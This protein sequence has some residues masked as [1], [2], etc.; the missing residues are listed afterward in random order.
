MNLVNTAKRWI[1]TLDTPSNIERAKK[2]IKNFS[3]ESIP[4]GKLINILLL[5][6]L[7]FFFYHVISLKTWTDML[8]ITFARSSGPGGQNVNKGN[9]FIM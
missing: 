8:T 7:V 5:Y 9:Y 3:K 6:E 1:S 2:W 4:R